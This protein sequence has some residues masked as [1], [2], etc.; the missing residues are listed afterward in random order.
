MQNLFNSDAVTRQRESRADTIRKRL[1]T[2]LS[3]L[4]PV[5]LSLITAPNQQGTGVSVLTISIDLTNTLTLL[6]M[7]EARASRKELVVNAPYFVQVLSE[8]RSVLDDSE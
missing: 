8:I 6:A 3:R 7:A 2:S 4:L 1:S 5:R